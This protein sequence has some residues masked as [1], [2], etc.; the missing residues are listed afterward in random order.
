M[1]QGDQLLR[2][3]RLDTSAAAAVRVR[4]PHRAVVLRSTAAEQRLVVRLRR[5]EWRPTMQLLSRAVTETVC[6]CRL[7][8]QQG[9]GLLRSELLPGAAAA[10][11]AL[12]Q[13]AAASAEAEGSNEATAAAAAGAEAAAGEACQQ[14]AAETGQQGSTSPAELLHKL[15]AAAPAECLTAQPPASW[16]PKAGISAPRPGQPFDTQ[17]FLA[18]LS[19]LQREGGAVAAGGSGA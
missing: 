14:A 19:E 3:V 18:R 2:S 5:S 11:A 15:R 17:A 13:P 10:L 6:G 8:S 12:S 16:R 1:R 7:W 9:S 4:K